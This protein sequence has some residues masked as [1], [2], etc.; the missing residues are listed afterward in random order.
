MGMPTAKFLKP[1]VVP[2]IFA[3]LINYLEP[4]S[5]N[6]RNDNKNQQ[7]CYI[8][9]SYID[10]PGSVVVYSCHAMVNT[11]LLKQALGNSGCVVIQVGDG[12]PTSRP[13]IL[14]ISLQQMGS[15]A[16]FIG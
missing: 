7:A 11:V 10:I 15:R 2:T 5:T 4:T 14:P 6:L 8:D 9:N 1:D 13:W 16:V 12:S 3:R